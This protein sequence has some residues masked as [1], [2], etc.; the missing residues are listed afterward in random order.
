MSGDVTKVKTSIGHCVSQDLHMN[1]GV[2]KQIKEKFG[3]IDE[4]KEQKVEVGGVAILKI[5][6]GRYIYNLVT[7]EKYSGKPT[8]RS[9]RESLKE[10]RTHCI[11]NSVDVISM[12]RIASG[13]DKME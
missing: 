10:M 13:L 5:G 4:L 7:K 12:P 11:N 1:A 3:R 2:A 6:P 8:Y 9:I